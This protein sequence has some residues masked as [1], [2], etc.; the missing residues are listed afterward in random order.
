MIKIDS[1]K[2]EITKIRKAA[3]VIRKGGIVAFPTETVYGLGGDALNPYA[4][5]Q[6]YEA[7]KRPLDNPIIVH[8]S[9][10]TEVY[11]LSERVSCIAKN[12]MD[13]FWPGPLTLV[14]KSLKIVPKESTGG[15]DTIA[16]RMPSSKVALS[17]I[18]ESLVPIAA[19]SANL[20][21]RPS[22]T[23]AEHVKEDLDGRIDMILDAGP[24]NIGIE[25]TVLDLT[26]D[27]PQILRPGGV[28]YEELKLLLHNVELHPFIISDKKTEFTYVHSPGL[29]HKHYA[30]KAKVIVIE[31]KQDSIVKKINE[32]S[33]KYMKFNKKVGVL[34]TD[35]NEKYYFADVVKSIGSR[36]TLT[37]IARNLFRLLREFDKE[38]VD[39]IIAEGITSKRLGLAVMNRLKKAANFNI[40]KVE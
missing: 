6:I 20:S 8:V 31:G 35:E 4:V 25:S 2:P 40:I 14:L 11:R 19:P 29:K 22:P 39:L 34:A 18:R 30:P 10:K 12:L 7:K 16:L 37:I 21:G 27:P 36:K 28:T 38:Y 17:L 33:Y 3:K 15:L 1:E 23:S 26:V 5:K 13:A 24:T 9:N 32:L